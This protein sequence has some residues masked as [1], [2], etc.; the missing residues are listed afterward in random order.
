MR[1]KQS[2]KKQLAAEIE[3]RLKEYYED[4]YRVQLG[5][6]DWK[7]RIQYRLREEKNLGHPN[8]KMIREWMNLQF[9]GQKILVVGAGTGAESVVFHQLGAKIHAIEPDPRALK[10]LG[11]KAELAGIP[12]D[13]FRKATAEKL[14]YPAD[15]FDFVY[16]Y[17]VIE[18]VQDVEQSIV[19]MIRVCKPGGLVYIQTPD[20]RFPYE[21]HYKSNRMAFSPK[22]LSA[23]QFWLQGK[24]IR[25]LFSVNFVTPKYLDKIFL[26]H[27]ILIHR[28]SPAWVHAWKGN[29]NASSFA[30]FARRF[31]FGKDQFIFLRKLGH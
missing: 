10:I 19:E 25:F 13:R 27:N 24:P 11:L 26:K 4:Y 29:N 16:C 31:G 2:R 7:E 20:Y 5:L 22:W 21:G 23:L 1:N 6:I 30:R 9:R 28:I 15:S 12:R 17:T 3:L 8:I 18:H 14:P